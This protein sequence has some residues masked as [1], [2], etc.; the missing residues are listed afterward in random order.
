MRRLRPCYGV[1]GAVVLAGA[2]VLTTSE[3]SATPSTR[4]PVGAS[5]SA[6][7]LSTPPSAGLAPIRSVGTVGSA[8][9]SG[10]AQSAPV[11]TF[12]SVTDT[13]RVPTVHVTSGDRYASDWVGIGGYSSNDLVQAGTE[14]DSK[15]GRAKYDAWTEVLPASEEVLKLTIHAGDVITAT[16]ALSG[17][18]WTMTVTDV[19]T[20]KT[21]SRSAAN[22]SK[23][24]S[25]EAIHERPEVGGELANLTATSDVTFDPGSYGTGATPSHPLLVTA[26]KAKLHRIVMVNNAGTAIIAYPSLPDADH[27]GFTVADGGKAPP[28]PKS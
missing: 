5:T 17:G 2:L 26:L 20:G 8:N 11:G 15:G 14:A 24:S 1:A 16:V 22:S 12:K 9:W 13:W 28:P 3:V 6:P 10:Y 18:V 19:T 23:E 25:V 7:M 21:A 4:I 27:D